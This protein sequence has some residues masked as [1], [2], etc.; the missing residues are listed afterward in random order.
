[1]ARPCGH[2]DVSSVAWPT[3]PFLASPSDVWRGA[4]VGSLLPCARQH[5][6]R[7]G[8]RGQRQRGPQLAP[9]GTPSVASS[10]A[11]LVRL[12]GFC[13]VERNGKSIFIC[14]YHY[15]ILFLFNVYSVGCSLHFVPCHS[16]ISWG[17]F[18][19]WGGWLEGGVGCFFL[20]LSTCLPTFS[21]FLLLPP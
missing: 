3:G 5:P 14:I 17:V 11:R 12:G 20:S 8:S 9:W 21:F 4:P 6:L 13:S 7:A 16:F 18:F 10:P 2:H 1:M 19:F 15:F